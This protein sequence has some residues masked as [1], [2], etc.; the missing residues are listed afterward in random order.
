MNN[1]DEREDFAFAIEDFHMPERLKLKAESIKCHSYVPKTER[2]LDSYSSNQPLTV[3]GAFTCEV[4]IGKNTEQ[5]EFIVIRESGEPLMGKETM[6]GLGDLRGVLRIGANIA[7]I[8]STKQRLQQQYPEGFS[9]VRKLKTRQVS[10]H[11]NPE[12]KQVAQP[13]RRIPFHLRGA[14]ESRIEELWT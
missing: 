14:V 12:V 13:L 10:L 5:A 8:T 11:I 2:K 4:S 1:I 3:K 7:A 9:G 6:K